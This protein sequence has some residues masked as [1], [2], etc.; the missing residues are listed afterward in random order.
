MGEI[1]VLIV[2]ALASATL[3]ACVVTPYP[4]PTYGYAGGGTVIVADR[5][6]PPVYVET[7]PPLPYE[8]AVWLGGHWGFEG[9]R[10]VWVPGRYE[11]ARAGYGW[12]PHQWVAGDGRW[13]LRGGEWTQRR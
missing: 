1:K 11:H 9:G 3:S 4:R 10:H 2:A 12:A 13:H 5:A 6:P 8:G 7:A